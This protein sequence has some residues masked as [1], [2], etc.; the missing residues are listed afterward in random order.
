VLFFVQV[1]SFFGFQNLHETKVSE[2]ESYESQSETC[3][4]VVIMHRAEIRHE[5]KKI[6]IDKGNKPAKEP[7]QTVMSDNETKV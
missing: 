6:C 1:A 5:S 4:W 7:N 3:L 2:C